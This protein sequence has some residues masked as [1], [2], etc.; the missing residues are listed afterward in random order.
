MILKLLIIS[1]ILVGFIVL[2]LSVKLI[3]DKDAV[4]SVHSVALND[5][6][7]KE[8]LPLKCKE[9]IESVFN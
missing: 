4:F 9:E 3:L 1:I 5:F 6:T 2:A 8:K 7:G